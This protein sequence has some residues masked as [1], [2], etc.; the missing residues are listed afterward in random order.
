MEIVVAWSWDHHTFPEGSALCTAILCALT[1][2]YPPHTGV[3]YSRYV[4]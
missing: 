1:Y 3:R 2:I 4:A